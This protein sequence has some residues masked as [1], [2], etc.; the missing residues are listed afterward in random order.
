MERWPDQEWVLID[1][2][3]EGIDV[4]AMREVVERYAHR[5][6]PGAADMQSYLGAV[7]E[8][9]P[10]R[11]VLGPLLNGRRPSGVCVHAGRLVANWGDPAALE[12]SFSVTKAYLS[13]LA[14]VAANTGLLSSVDEQVR[15]TVPHEAFEGRRHGR[16]T[17]RHLL[18]QTSEWSG[19]L[20]G[21]PWWADPQG[22]QNR[23][24][25]LGSPGT[26]W[27][28]NDV[29][30]NVLA[31]ALLYVFGEPLESVLADK[32][33]GVIDGSGTVQWH[34]YRD[35]YVEIDGTR[36]PSVSGGAHWGGGVWASAYD[37][38]RVGL[39]Y[40]RGGR[41]R[42]GTV[43]T[44]DWVQ[45]SWAPC[46]VKPEYGFLWWRNDEGTIFREAPA[47]GR[48]ARGNHG[49]QLIWV[50]PARDLVVVSRWTED[51]GS[52]LCDLSA[53]VRGN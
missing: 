37:H 53:A 49:R 19:E 51:V 38:A 35:S 44:T 23:D 47:S 36:L 27:A 4:M 8:D 33:M 39:L 50:D 3:I 10:Y 22:G 28:Y 24:H 43:I 11:Q 34:G 26:V 2:D 52:L 32:V 30:V 13:L 7:V 48:C 29:R 17:W 46:P 9:Q 45:D 42:D 5:G 18:Q 1:E 41:W 15:C 21:I 31:L 6:T 40:L 25:P 12:M 14:G 16:I 20:W